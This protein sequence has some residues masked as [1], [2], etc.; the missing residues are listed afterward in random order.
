MRQAFEIAWA[1]ACLYGK[2]APRLVVV[3]NISFKKPVLIGSLLLLS[4]QIVYTEG[5]FMQIKVHAE[6]IDPTTSRRELSNDFYFKF[7]APIP[8]TLPQVFPKTYAEAMTYI[9][10]K[11]HM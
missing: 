6:T 9:D 11:R 5:N 4:S 2:T 7:F 8:N 10:G 3:D 1:N